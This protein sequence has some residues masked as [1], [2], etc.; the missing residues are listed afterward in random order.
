MIEERIIEWLD[1]GDS[2]QKIDLYERPKLI[3]YF[4]YHHLLLKYGIN[5]ES[6]DIVFQLMFFLQLISLS[7]INIDKKVITIEE[8]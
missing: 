3:K 5:S 2:V 4:Q 7:S 6:L 1:L 8:V